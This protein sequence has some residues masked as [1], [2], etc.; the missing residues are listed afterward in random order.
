M[1]WT[2]SYDEEYA[3]VETVY[4][5]PLSPEDLRDVIR[6]NLVLATEKGATRFLGDCTRLSRESSA[7][8]IYALGDFIATLEVPPGL[9]EA[10]LLPVAPEAERDLRFY[11]T[12]A[13]NRGFQVRVFDDRAGALLWL[14]S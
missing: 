14:T 3:V 10:I 1:P 2:L 6:A 13:L 8:S 11:E 5:D 4:T 7:Q 9:K 12:V